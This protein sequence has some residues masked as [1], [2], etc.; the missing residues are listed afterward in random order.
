MKLLSHTLKMIL[1]HEYAKGVE[2]GEMM[3]KEVDLE[4]LFWY[5][6]KWL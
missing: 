1:P 3:R 2:A 5:G 4:L 6:V